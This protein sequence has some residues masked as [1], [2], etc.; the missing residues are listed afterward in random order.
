EAGGVALAEDGVV[1]RLFAEV[2]GEGDKVG[3]NAGHGGTIIRTGL[4]LRRRRRPQMG[5]D[6]P[7][8]RQRWVQRDPDRTM[9]PAFTVTPR[10][11]PIL[12]RPWEG[13]PPLQTTAAR[14]HARGRSRGLC[15]GPRL[16]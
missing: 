14:S 16:A 5:P 6:S 9:D 1:A 10:R 12:A 11:G 3:G 2:A 13:T 8:W 15:R 7:G 4:A